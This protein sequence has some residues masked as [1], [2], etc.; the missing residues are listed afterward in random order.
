[1]H[2]KMKVAIRGDKPGPELTLSPQRHTAFDQSLIPLSAVVKGC[3]PERY[4]ALMWKQMCV[5]EVSGRWG[6]V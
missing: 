2:L 4:L 1:M 3:V 5:W 6:L